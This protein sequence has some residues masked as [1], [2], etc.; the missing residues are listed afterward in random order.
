[1]FRVFNKGLPGRLI[2]CKD[3]FAAWFGQ[4]KERFFSI[5]K[6]SSNSF[7]HLWKTVALRL[8]T[9]MRALN[10]IWLRKNTFNYVPL[11]KH[12]AQIHS[13]KLRVLHERDGSQQCSHLQHTNI[14]KQQILVTFQ[15]SCIVAFLSKQNMG[16]LSMKHY[17]RIYAYKTTL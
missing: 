8:K 7:A 6:L 16:E 5:T 9:L 2:V 1:M 14:D 10:S 11:K 4:L 12:L 13:Q 3:D 15:S 17:W